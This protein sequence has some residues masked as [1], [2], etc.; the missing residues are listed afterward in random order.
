MNVNNKN[1][2][3]EGGVDDHENDHTKIS[4]ASDGDEPERGNSGSIA[5]NLSTLIDDE[6]YFIQKVSRKKQNKN[7]VNKRATYGIQLKRSTGKF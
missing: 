6:K 5:M 1:N 2:D 7:T 3:K 4:E